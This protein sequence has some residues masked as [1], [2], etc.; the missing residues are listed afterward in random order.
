V[1]ELDAS[2]GDRRGRVFG[3]TLSPGLSPRSLILLLLP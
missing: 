2:L 1:I 3:I